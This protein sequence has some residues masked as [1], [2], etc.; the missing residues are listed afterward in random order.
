MKIAIGS[1]HAGFHYK[2]KIR[3]H[4]IEL[5]HE[6]QDFGTCDD[7]PDDYPDRIRPVAEAVANGNY[8]IGIV[9]GGS[10]NG[11]SMVA[12]KIKGIR[13]AVCW[14]ETSARLAKAHNNANIISLGQR[15]MTIETAL[16]IVD[17][18]MS[19]RFQGGRHLRRI[20]KIEEN[21]MNPFK[22][23]QCVPC[24]VGLPPL[25]ESEEDYL[26]KEVATWTLDRTNIHQL[27]KSYR[28]SDFNEAMH[29]VNKVADLV[30]LEDH[31]PNI[32]I[33][34][35]QVDLKIYTHKIGG[36]HENDFILAS[37]I[38]DLYKK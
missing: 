37:K 20:Q 33:Q 31:H 6:V 26:K 8:E 14:D 24:R 22:E 28:F 27:Q 29:F 36:L 1:D 30:N 16:L 32:C 15:M 34:Y 35:N 23:K 19:T 3:E 11:E 21:E 7:K 38:D 2:T 12:N 10:G 17:T 13:C 25:S 4:L 18:W 9:L 5:G